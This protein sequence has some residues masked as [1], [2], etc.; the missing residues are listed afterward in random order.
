MSYSI[1]A[2]G[3]NFWVIIINR[4]GRRNGAVASHKRISITNNLVIGWLPSITID[5]PV[6]IN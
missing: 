4:N 2:E 5:P 3:K 1:D 6:P